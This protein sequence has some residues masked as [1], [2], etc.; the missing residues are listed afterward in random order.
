MRGFPLWLLALYGCAAGDSAAVDSDEGSGSCTESLWFRDA[1]GDGYGNPSNT[2]LACDAEAGLVGNGSDCD[3]SDPLV[4]RPAAW[5]KDRDRD[6]YGTATAEP[7]EAC[8]KP[9]DGA[10][11]TYDCD[12]TRS[13]V[14]PDAPEVCNDID[15]DCN[16]L[17]DGP[18]SVDVRTFWQDGDGD[19]HAPI[20]AT[21]STEACDPPEGFAE[22]RDDCDDADPARHPD[23]DELCGGVD[24]NCDGE[25]D[26]DAVDGATYYLDGDGDGFG[27]DTSV[28]SCDPVPGWLTAGGDCDDADAGVAPGAVELCNA[29]DDDCDGTVDEPIA[30][31]DFD[32][33]IT[34][35]TAAGDAKHS[36]KGAPDG[37][38]LVTDGLDETGAVW[39]DQRAGTTFYASLTFDVSGGTGGEGFTFAF[40]DETSL[41]SLGNDGAGLGVEGLDG[42]AVAL[43]THQNLVTDPTGEWLSLR[44]TRD[45]TLV[46]SGDPIPAVSGGGEQL[47]EVWVDGADV[48]V[49][50]DGVTYLTATIPGAL[51]ASY[52]VGVTSSTTTA[53]DSHNVDDL[54]VGCAP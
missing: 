34:G 16:E 49:A 54:Y 40:L 26:A 23:A 5:W 53:W 13:D 22:L 51:P 29:A 44:E 14:N 15:D 10:D 24:E 35:M 32:L 28:S 19:G 36:F 45:F 47:L 4:Q 11:N 2:V 12:D 50:I 38:L 8:E 25:L 21:V 39:L 18:D 20:D 9:L 46:A 41:L 43:D 42:W 48:T 6:G 7:V 31:L 17:V 30:D 27:G 1:D 3:D 52:L 37:R 33:G